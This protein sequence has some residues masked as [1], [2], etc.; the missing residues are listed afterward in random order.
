MITLRLAIATSIKTNKAIESIVTRVMD[1]IQ[2]IEYIYQ[3]VDPGVVP[4]PPDKA[5]GLLIT[6]DMD[7]LSVMDIKM[8][9]SDELSL[10]Y[11]GMLDDVRDR[12]IYVD[13]IWSG[14]KEEEEYA[15][16]LENA[17]RRL[18][19]RLR[20]RLLS[21]SLK[22]TVNMMP[23]MMWIKSTEGGFEYV[24]NSFVNTIG[25][26]EE[27]VLGKTGEEVANMISDGNDRESFDYTSTDEIVMRSRKQ[28]V[29]DEMLKVP[30]GI[31]QYSVTKAP[32]FDVFGNIW[33]IAGMA[34]DVSDFKNVGVEFSILIENMP[35][36]LV[37]CDSE[38]NVLQMNASFKDLTRLDAAELANL[39]YLEWKRNNLIPATARTLNEKT[40]STR[41]DFRMRD[42]FIMRYFALIEQEIKDHADQLTGY[43]IVFLDMTTQKMYEKAILQ[44]ANSD[45]L[46][47]LFNRKYFFDYIKKQWGTPMTL[48][49][50]DLDH[51]KEVNDTYGHARGDDVLRDT[52]TLITEIFYDG[53]SARLGGD[54]F[55]VV[56]RGKQDQAIMDERIERLQKGLGDLFRKDSL[57][58]SISVGEMYTDGSDKDLDKFVQEADKRMYDMKAAKKRAEGRLGAVGES[59]EEAW[60]NRD[61]ELDKRKGKRR[62]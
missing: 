27:E 10:I 16:L 12:I 30:G 33:G 28:A 61:S 59:D 15:T 51:F 50:M 54:E 47:G 42:G 7:T 43:Y 41:Q 62:D 22:S 39:D 3:K 6:D 1:S 23:E 11:V 57:P 24:N 58:V 37:I 17:V 26:R 18:I 25:F 8:A 40:N 48:L 2:G 34:H 5:C 20:K 14:G 36:P 60:R 4:E 13:E 29:F 46:T 55:T 21:E 56:L 49:Y 35:L 9:A 31:R 38:Y 44:E 53:V 45:S 19:Q 32:L 52:A